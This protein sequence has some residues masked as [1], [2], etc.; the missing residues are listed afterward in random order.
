MR[1]TLLFAI[2]SIPLLLSAFTNQAKFEYNSVD[3]DDSIIRVENYAK[4][5]YKKLNISNVTLLKYNSNDEFNGSYY[6]NYLKNT[7]AVSGYSKKISFSAYI[8]AEGY[9]DNNKEIHISGITQA[10]EQENQVYGGLSLSSIFRETL[11]LDF[12][13]DMRR[14]ALENDDH[15]ESDQLIEMKIQL[16]TNEYIK[17]FFRIQSF[18][19]LNDNSDYNYLMNELGTDFY[20][21]FNRQHYFKS[22]LSAIYDTSE[23]YDENRLHCYYSLRHLFKF[24]QDWLTVNRIQ[25]R[26]IKENGEVLWGTSFVETI[27]QRNLFYNEDNDLALIQTGTKYYTIDE[28]GFLKLKI[29]YPVS[30]I[31]LHTEYRHFY[32]LDPETE[33]ELHGGLRFKYFNNSAYLNYIFSMENFSKLD[34]TQTHSVSIQYIW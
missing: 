28:Q 33:S 10:M 15:I 4:F 2:L 31:T 25:A 24:S 11:S 13:I 22:T 32:G 34:D 17:P 7:I 12:K 9:F 6:N 16:V 27:V 30:M 29:E 8:G 14:L 20:F 5:K 23:G 26:M 21:D 18:N 19:D 1:R 3:N